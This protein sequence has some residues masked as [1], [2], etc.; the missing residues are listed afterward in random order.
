MADNAFEQDTIDG[1]A[2]MTHIDGE[3]VLNVVGGNMLYKFRI[4]IT[5]V[6]RLNCETADALRRHLHTLVFNKE[7]T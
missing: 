1:L 4:P 5:A 7:S 6:S 2:F 3:Q